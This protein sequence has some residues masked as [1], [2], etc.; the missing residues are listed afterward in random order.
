MRLSRTLRLVLLTSA[1]ASLLVF[2]ATAQAGG[3]ARASIKASP[4]AL[5]I[6]EVATVTGRGFKARSQFSL[7]LNDVKVATGTVSRTGRV[8]LSFTV[9][10]G[11]AQELNVKVTSSSRSATTTV[12]VLDGSSGEDGGFIGDEPDNPDDPDQ[13]PEFNF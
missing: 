6:G 5:S 12:I 3:K 1:I 4:K 9:P 11:S 13:A 7:K 10:E 8:K 2:A